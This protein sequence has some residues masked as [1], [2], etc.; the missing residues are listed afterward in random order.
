MNIARDPHDIATLQVIKQASY[1]RL[2]G[3]C[4]HAWHWSAVAPHVEAATLAE[5]ESF[6][7]DLLHE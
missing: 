2:F 5:V 6:V 1:E 3:L 7:R 4:R